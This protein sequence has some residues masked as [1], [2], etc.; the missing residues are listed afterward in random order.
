M[1]TPCLKWNLLLTLVLCACQPV[2]AF[3]QA[4]KAALVL[5]DHS[6]AAVG[7]FNNMRTPAAL[8]G[9]A[10]VP[11][12]ILN[13][14]PVAKDDSKRTKLFKRAYILLGVASLLSEILAVTYSTIAINKLVEVAHAPTAGV[15][16]LIA[17]HHELA[18][19]GTNIHFLLGMMG[20]GLIV[21][22][23]ASLVF[24]NP[25]GQIAGLWSMAAFMQALSVVNRGIAQ[26]PFG[27]NM[28]TLTLRYG[29]LLLANA[30]GVMSTS[31]VAVFL[32]S[33]FLLAKA[34]VKDRSSEDKEKQK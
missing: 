7:L 16:A 27:S 9:G 18:W 14:A 5:K 33:L 15:V 30:T 3:G 11:L 31:A 13:A 28:F 8:I 12:G 6:A 19:I 21:G 26:S 4:A 29:S 22:A 34:I 32:Y 25:T 17:N 23:K 10:L 24:G 1:F 20:F 2:H